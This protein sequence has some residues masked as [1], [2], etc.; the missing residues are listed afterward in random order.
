MRM[1]LTFYS[2]AAVVYNFVEDE[3]LICVIKHLISMETQGLEEYSLGI[4]LSTRPPGDSRVVDYPGLNAS[5]IEIEGWSW[6][7]IAAEEAR[8]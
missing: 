8:R 3:K 6:L 5:L 4:T 2:H 7:P 1:A